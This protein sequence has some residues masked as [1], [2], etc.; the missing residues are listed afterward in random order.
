LWTDT[1]KKCYDI[2]NLGRG[3]PIS[4]IE[5]IQTVADKL[6]VEP[7]IEYMALQPGEVLITYADISHAAQVLSYNPRKPFREGIEEFVSWYK[8]TGERSSNEYFQVA[9]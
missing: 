5:M 7:V 3:N 6:G 1:E 8:H 4:L 2:F 9:G